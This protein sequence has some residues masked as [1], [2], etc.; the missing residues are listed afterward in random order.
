MYAD[1]TLNQSSVSRLFTFIV[2]F[3][4]LTWVILLE[5]YSGLCKFKVIANA[6]AVISE[7]LVSPSCLTFESVI[8][9]SV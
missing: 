9:T 7:P 4:I 2:D 5:I 3:Q 1:G 6:E 8:L